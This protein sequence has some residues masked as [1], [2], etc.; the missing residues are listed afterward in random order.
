MPSVLDRGV[1]MS[2][3]PRRSPAP[4]PRRRQRR[5]VSSSVA[6][7]CGFHDEYVLGARI[8]EG[9]FGS[10]FSARRAVASGAAQ[11]VAVKVVDLRPGSGRSADLE[12][13]ER[14]VRREVAMLQA[15]PRSPHIVQCLGYQICEDFA[16]VVMEHGGMRLLRA[17]EK[18]S[19]LTEVTSC[20]A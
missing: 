6:P 20:R 11:A 7:E 2:S 10:V 4:A 9:A 19:D 18:S 1:S 15:A 16:Y 3:V 5:S 17:M 12:K 8:G 14:S 13:R